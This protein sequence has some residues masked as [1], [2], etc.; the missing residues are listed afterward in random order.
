MAAKAAN[1]KLEAPHNRVD[2]NE[3]QLPSQLPSHFVTDWLTDW[4]G[5]LSIMAIVTHSASLGPLMTPQSQRWWAN[6]WTFNAA[7][8][9][10]SCVK[11]STSRGMLLKVCCCLSTGHGISGSENQLGLVLADD[12]APWVHKTEWLVRSS[13]KVHDTKSFWVGC[14]YSSSVNDGSCLSKWFGKQLVREADFKNC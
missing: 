6:Y 3:L 5:T 13:W 2:R 10:G 9:A 11:C 1:F 7:I 4:H 8:G 14:T 12:S